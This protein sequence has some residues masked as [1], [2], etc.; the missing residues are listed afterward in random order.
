MKNE[1][2]QNLNLSLVPDTATSKA[3]TAK[4]SDLSKQPSIY[5][6]YS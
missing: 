3:V 4:L 5:L 1:I 2:I 6:F